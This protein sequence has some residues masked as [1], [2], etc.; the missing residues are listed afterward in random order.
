VKSKKDSLEAAKEYAFLLLKFRLRSIKELEERLKKKKFNPEIIKETI[1]FL[2]EKRFLDDTIFARG[3][4]QSRIKRPMGI[5][6]IKQE[7]NLKG[8]D[9]EIIESS[10]RELKEDYSEE[11]IVREL[12]Q[13]RF[14]KLKDI[15]PRSAQRR[16]YAYLMRRGFP[17]DIV[18]DAISNLCKQTY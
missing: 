13:E 7:L 18:I 15:E 16:V 5:R 17:P 10:I 1:A 14:S 6:K 3:W 4:I 12:A 2:K 8:I 11:D 9:K